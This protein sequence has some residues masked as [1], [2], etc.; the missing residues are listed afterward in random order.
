MCA[1]LAAFR[2]LNEVNNSVCHKHAIKRKEIDSAQ[3]RR[4]YSIRQ[5]LPVMSDATTTASSRL[6][7]VLVTR[8]PLLAK[9][10]HLQLCCYVY[11]Y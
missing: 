2:Y 7:R 4:C 1:L 3:R 9:D 5:Y 11:N 8:H 10:L 6:F